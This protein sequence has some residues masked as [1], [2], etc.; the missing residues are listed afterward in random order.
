MTREPYLEM[1]YRHG[2]CLAG[3]LYLP[4]DPKDSVIRSEPRGEDL[5]VDFSAEGKPI[6]IEILTPARVR[7]EDIVA[8]LHELNISTVDQ[9]ELTPLAS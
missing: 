2:R 8:I 1:T 4:R 7:P 6:G 5:V 9:E 3:Y